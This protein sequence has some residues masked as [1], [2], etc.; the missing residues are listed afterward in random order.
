MEKEFLD[1]VEDNAAVRTWSETTQREKGDSLAEG[2]VSELWDFTRI[3]VTQNSLQDCITFGKVDLVPTIE[4][5]M[6]LLRCSKIQVDRAYSRA[7]NVPTFLKK[8]MNINGMRK[9]WVAAWIKR[10]DILEEKWMAIL[11][12]LQ[13]EDIM[14][15]ALWL[16]P[17]EILYRCGD[18]DW[19]RRMKRLAVTPMM[20]LEYNEWWVRRINDN[21][22]KPSQGNSQSI[23]EHLRVVPSKLEIIRQDFERRNVKFEKKIEQVEEEKMNLRLD[24]DLGKNSEQWHEEI[25]DEKNKTDRWERKFQEYRNQNSVIELRA[26]LSRIEEMKKRIKELEMTLQNCEIRI[27]YL[28]VN[29]DRHNEQLH[30]FQNQVRNRD[31]IMGEAVVQ[32]RDVADHLQ[33][34]AVQADTLSTQAEVYPRK[35][36]VTIKPQHF[37]VGTSTP[38]NFQAGSGSN[39]ADNPI[40]PGIHDF[41]EVAEKEKNKRGIAKTTRGKV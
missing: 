26:S 31:H 14:W 19:T 18:F 5:Y 20:T 24:M 30:Y 11:Q 7:V 16:L 1:K 17:D 38:M 40:N 15:R 13:E 9:Q 35:S 10:D 33:T 8:L 6:A 29:E 37:Q 3:S 25:R 36:S 34:L 41:D 39:P 4:E 28:E 32:I 27:E 2:Y 23:E 21:I 22:P 12:N